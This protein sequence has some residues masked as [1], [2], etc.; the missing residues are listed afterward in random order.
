MPRFELGPASL[1]PE[2]SCP[3]S[4]P[5]DPRI[6][7]MNSGHSNGE[8]TCWRAGLTHARPLAN[9]QFDL[10]LRNEDPFRRCSHLAAEGAHGVDRGIA[11]NAVPRESNRV[12]E[13]LVEALYAL[14]RFP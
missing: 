3:G 13:D 4:D 14:W 10:F 5:A 6:S 11:S 1:E 2:G 7:G 8:R 9:G 12:P